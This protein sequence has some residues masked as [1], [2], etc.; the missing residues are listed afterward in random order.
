[1]QFGP[2]NAPADFQGDTNNAI[3]KALDDLVSA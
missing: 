2:T 3:S 1:M